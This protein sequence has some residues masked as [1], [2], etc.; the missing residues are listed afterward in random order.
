MPHPATGL[1]VLGVVGAG[2]LAQM[3]HQAA[4]ALGV[5][6]R[7]LAGSPAE[8]AAL[9]G[10]DVVLGDHRSYDAV[11]ALA[12]GCDAVT[13]DHEHVPL[14]VADKLVAA[15]VALRPGPGALPYV[16]DKLRM[17]ERLAAMGLP[18]PAWREVHDAAGVRATAAGHGWPVVLKTAVGGYDGKGVW[19][20][21]GP[22]AAEEVLGPLARA[23]LAAFAEQWVPYDR[24]LAALVA[25]SASGEARAWP[26]VQTVQRAGICREVIAPAPGLHEAL[27]GEATALA[28][29]LAEE[30]DVVGVLAVELFEAG[31]RLLV[32]ELAMRPHNS[33]HWTMD[34]AVT[35]QFEQHVRAVLG[36]PL[37]ATEPTVPCTVMVNVLGGDG[38]SAA[39]LAGR[40]PLALGADP[41][42]HVH[43][44]GKAVRPGRK[45]GHVNVCG[46]D[47]DA[48]LERGRR[49]AA[50][51][52]GERS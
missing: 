42:L 38:P 52:A 12:D 26:V 9:A 24:E 49:A 13:L 43:L 32:N 17:R 37:G 41:G 2:Q 36:W 14:P 45:V 5:H 25:R 33:G 4:I 8:S 22:A 20:V 31:G 35:S 23:G 34:G 16:Q 44:Y 15:G 7:V 51:L 3:M 19:V 21:D 46:S 47:P 50:V 28:L 30:L 48:L 40:L 27:A 29:R 18:M 39:D 1:P 6:V 10:A 11:A